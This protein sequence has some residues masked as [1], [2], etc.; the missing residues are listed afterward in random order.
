MRALTLS[1]IPCSELV[2]RAPA[3]AL[4]AAEQTALA[5]R[6]AQMHEEDLRQAVNRAEAA[7]RKLQVADASIAAAMVRA[8]QA[9]DRIRMATHRVQNA[10]HFG[11]NDWVREMVVGM[12]R[13]ATERVDVTAAVLAT[14][15]SAS[16]GHRAKNIL[17]A[18]QSSRPGDNTKRLPGGAATFRAGDRAGEKAAAEKAAGSRVSGDAAAPSAPGAAARPGGA[19]AVAAGAASGPSAVAES[20]MPGTAEAR[21]VQAVPSISQL[22]PPRLISPL[23]DTLVSIAKN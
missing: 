5:E 23:S 15:S 3:V 10:D 11:V 20:E 18:G 4:A 14:A 1:P 16:V 6:V 12:V 9:E 19:W 8:A 13:I 7:E 22:T 17:A 21:S 2:T